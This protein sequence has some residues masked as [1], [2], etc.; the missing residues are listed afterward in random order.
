MAGSD[1]KDDRDIVERTFPGP[2]RI[3]NRYEGPE[4]ED[5]KIHE[6]RSMVRTFLG[7][8]AGVMSESEMRA[9]GLMPPEHTPPIMKNGLEPISLD[10]ATSP[11]VVPMDLSMVPDD[12]LFK[13]VY[14]RF[15][16]AKPHVRE[17]Q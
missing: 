2:W 15:I 5:R 14:L 7:I 17:K 10:E 11:T 6:A 16:G 4:D 9:R 13:E 3:I 1:V 8:G 12:V